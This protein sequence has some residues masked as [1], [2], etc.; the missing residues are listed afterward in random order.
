LKDAKKYPGTLRF[1]LAS[2]LY[3]DAL[4]TIVTTMAL[5]AIYVMGFTKGSEATLLLV[6]TIPAIVGSYGI[7]RMVDRIGP[8]RSL[9]WVLI[10]WMVLLIGLLVAP[11]RTSFW[12]I[13]AAIGL[14]FGG[15]ATAER[16]LLLSLVPDMEAGRFFS[17]MV[18]SSRAAAVVGPFVWA[19]AVDGLKPIVGVSAAYR[20]GVATVFIGMA[21]AWW[22]LRKVPD[23]FT[24]PRIA[25]AS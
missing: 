21:F 24:M 3:Q 20:L 7:G 4:G 9:S 15:I 22:V 18:L 5:Y 12:I 13:G 8:K 19:L 25:R 23:N 10:G 16:P 1:I 11:T 17:L 14:I 6:L 2:F